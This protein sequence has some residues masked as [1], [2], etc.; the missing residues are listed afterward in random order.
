MAKSN[1][2]PQWLH[3]FDLAKAWLAYF[4]KVN[5]S[6]LSACIKVF[7][8]YAT[9]VD[10][11]QD[12]QLLTKKYE[13]LL[14]AIAPLRAFFE[15]T[16]EVKAAILK[17]EGF[18]INVLDKQ[19]A[20]VTEMTTKEQAENALRDD[21]VL[22]IEN[23]DEGVQ[24][25]Q[26]RQ[27]YKTALERKIA[28]LPSATTTTSAVASSVVDAEKSTKLLGSFKT[29]WADAKQAE[30][31]EL[32]KYIAAISDLH[33][34]LSRTHDLVGG[35]KEA[36]LRE[37]HKYLILVDGLKQ[38][39]DGLLMSRISKRD[40]IEEFARSVG[41]AK[42]FGA[43]RIKLDEYAAI[44]RERN[45]AKKKFG[46]RRVSELSDRTGG[47]DR[48]DIAAAL[49][50]QGRGGPRSS[51]SA[52]GLQAQTASSLPRNFGD[53]L[54]TAIS[55]ERFEDAKKIAL[56]WMKFAE[57]EEDSVKESAR[58]GYA[59]YAI[60]FVGDGSGRIEPRAQLFPSRL[61]EAIRILSELKDTRGIGEEEKK[62]Y[63]ATMLGF[64]I[65][66]I[67]ISDLDRKPL[68]PAE[69]QK[70]YA[71][72]GAVA[73]PDGVEYNAVRSLKADRLTVIRQAQIAGIDAQL[74]RIGSEIRPNSPTTDQKWKELQ[75][76]V[77]AI[78]IDSPHT[79][80]NDV[81][82]KKR[83]LIA[84][85]EGEI[86]KLS[87]TEIGGTRRRTVSESEQHMKF[88]SE[89]NGAK[90][91][92]DGRQARIISA[93]WLS[94]AKSGANSAETLNAAR[95]AF[96]EAQ[97]DYAKTIPG[98]ESLTFIDRRREIE[99]VYLTLGGLADGSDKNDALEQVKQAIRAL[100]NLEKKK[101]TDE[102]S[103][104]IGKINSIV[105]SGKSQNLQKS[106]IEQV[107]ENWRSFQKG[108]AYKAPWRLSEK[109]LLGKL[110]E[111]VPRMTLEE[112][113][114]AL[115]TDPVVGVNA[116]MDDD[117]S[118]QL[119]ARYKAVLEEKAPADTSREILEGFQKRW[120]TAKINVSTQHL[121]EYIEAITR[122]CHEI[123]DQPVDEIF[124]R[125][126]D[127]LLMEIQEYLGL[128]HGIKL[129]RDA[130]LNTVD[131]KPEKRV[132]EDALGFLTENKSKLFGT[133]FLQ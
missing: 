88:G 127:N 6:P 64:K 26:K 50:A 10:A 18:I 52:R 86:G 37:I 121:D 16:P 82:E 72:V 66:K 5:K 98:L 51:L 110:I 123:E 90:S 31:L 118:R 113:S 4:G 77:E 53:E 93:Q 71:D 87:S 126:K 92:G 45:E 111:F 130:V 19:I 20:L 83:S 128:I 119:R 9:G 85:I 40:E 60:A 132:I 42:L 79:D 84:E 30:G 27:Q 73:I 95:A 78:E 108:F 46:T 63:D 68:P 97:V 24:V 47:E 94:Y 44:L 58:R 25:T 103:K 48:G 11:I 104:Y 125:E 100:I 12:I 109:G 67:D 75:T 59:E 96:I 17:I 49:I 38:D 74:E 76:A 28:T 114:T 61:D 8:D 34:A 21:A 1:D 41:G 116:E 120:N 3:A 22:L 131:P 129:Q 62:Y 115:R 43:A 124:R 32:D 39:G 112:A 106:E 56:D 57:H 36:L 65:E 102:I 29:R 15:P 133:A 101:A 91:R 99:Q 35:E 13:L 117:K 69:L 54:S 33:A 122:L 55:E 14:G 70:L 7:E 80:F 23:A 107:L 2:P 89:Y 105:I 81:K